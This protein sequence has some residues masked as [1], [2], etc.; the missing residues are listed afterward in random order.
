[1]G[2]LEL[3]LVLFK[4]LTTFF[5]RGGFDTWLFSEDY[6]PRAGEA[7]PAAVVAMETI[8]CTFYFV[9]CPAKL[10][11]QWEGEKVGTVSLPK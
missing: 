11:I 10:L 2:R 6:A 8:E 3:F 7:S 9:P 4:T 1:M 5:G